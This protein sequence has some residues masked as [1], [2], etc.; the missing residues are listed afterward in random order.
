MINSAIVRIVDLCA[1]YRWTAIGIG[2]LLMLGA[3]AFDAARFSVNTD[4]QGLISQNLPW[5]QRQLQMSEAFPQNGIAVVVKAPTAENAELATNQLAQALAKNPKLFPRVGQPDSGEFFERNG[6]LFQSQDEVKKSAAGL[7]RAQ[8]LISTLAGDPSL[9]GVMRALSLAAGGVEEGKLK[10][11]QLAFTLS[12][13]NQTL[14][15]VLSASPPRSPGRNC[16]RATRC[17][18][19]SCG[20]SSKSSRRSILPNFSPDTRRKKAFAAPRRI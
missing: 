14:G 18:H 20:T 3:A 5:H 16:C 6:L 11:D 13:A 4:V 8:P 1:R 9:R 7:A 2:V 10:L 15:D 12:L 17:R 19:S